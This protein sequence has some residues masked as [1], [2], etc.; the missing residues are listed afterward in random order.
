MV[1]FG[2]VL[3]SAGSVVPRFRK[4]IAEGKNLTITHKDIKRYFMSIPEASR[5]VIQA[6][7]LG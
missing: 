6:G 7:A 4:Q 2:N 1:R 3:D 5:L